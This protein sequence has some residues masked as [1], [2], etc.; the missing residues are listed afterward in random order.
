MTSQPAP[1]FQ[2]PPRGG[3]GAVH[4][5]TGADAHHFQQIAHMH[6]DQHIHSHAEATPEQLY[7]RGRSLLDHEQPE[8]AHRH[9]SQAVS[10]GHATPEALYY[11]MLS[12]VRRR[13]LD[14]LTEDELRQL[15]EIGRRLRGQPDDEYRAA[16]GALLTL[17][18]GAFGLTPE[19]PDETAARGTRSSLN[20][21]LVLKDLPAPR[22]DE[23]T[24]HLRGIIS[25]TEQ[26]RLDQEEEQEIREQRMGDDRERRVPLFFIPDPERPVPLRPVPPR[27]GPVRTV[28]FVLSALAGGAG[29]V[30]LARLALAG[31]VASAVPGLLLV[32]AGA[33]GALRY[34]LDAA[35]RLRRLAEEEDGRTRSVPATRRS[36]AARLYADELLPPAEAHAFHNEIQTIVRTRFD[37]QLAGDAQAHEDLAGWQRDTEI[38]RQNLAAELTDLYARHGRRPGAWSL[39][40]LVQHHAAAA[41]HAWRAGTLRSDEAALRVPPTGWLATAAGAL[42]V[43]AGAALTL[44]AATAESVSSALG[45]VLLLGA[46][47]F[48]GVRHGFA[49]YAER[50]R[51]AADREAFAR[52]HEEELGVY[53]WWRAHLA[54]WRPTD[55][56]MARWLDYDLRHLRRQAVVQDQL[57]NSDIETAFFVLEGAPGC[58]RARVPGR[59]QRYSDYIVRLFVLTSGGVRLSVCTLDFF[60]ALDQGRSRHSF[61]YDVIGTADLDE[62]SVPEQLRI[63]LG[64]QRRIDVAVES[65]GRLHGGTAGGHPGDLDATQLRELALRSSGISRARDILMGVAAEGRAWFDQQ[66]ARNRERFREVVAGPDVV[67]DEGLDG[68]VE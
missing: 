53:D 10:R 19:Q 34:G 50:R 21:E 36:G 30:S 65:Y 62:E 61:R 25:G 52:R 47:G 55:G 48:F 18:L 43:L 59:P 35:W 8:E 67:E 37:E 68:P 33:A 6:G 58:L 7:R 12:I 29:L 2:P 46:G 3:A 5:T 17:L 66:R 16:G 60:T 23:I 57:R 9:L 38:A 54:R 45:A 1:G 42:A 32:A 41:A 31:D 22:R 28:W 39:D 4:F 44:P 49:C 14:E 51:F 24:N 26:D 13:A 64:N 27:F 40:Y 56:E 20:V 15:R 63:T 11:L